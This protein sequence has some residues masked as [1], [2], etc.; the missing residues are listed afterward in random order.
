MG[1]SGQGGESETRIDTSTSIG[2]IHV[3]PLASGIELYFPPLR[4]AGSALMLALFGL[5]C[6][7]I[8]L[9][10]IAGLVRSGDTAAASMLALAFAGVFA[11]P[12][13]LLGQFFIVIAVWTAA[14]SVRVEVS[15]NGLRV[16][17]NLFGYT[18]A[19][20]V[21]AADDIAAI[22]SRLAARYVGAFGPA[23]YYR[24]F[25]RARNFPH[26]LLVA[27]SLQGPAMAEEVRQLVVE[28]LARPALAAAGVHAHLAQEDSA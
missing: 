21:M 5:A 15:T 8:G 28:H 23:R 24:L 14:N 25:A 3:T 18:V 16:V 1:E 26:P 4:A 13:L 6:S 10:A 27:D 9:A 22:D 7:V 19:R 17:R 11:L 20:R 2:A 12:L